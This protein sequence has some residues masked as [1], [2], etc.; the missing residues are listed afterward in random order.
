MRTTRRED[1]TPL[2][3]LIE[4]DSWNSLRVLEMIL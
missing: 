3:L 1:L 2:I 4:D